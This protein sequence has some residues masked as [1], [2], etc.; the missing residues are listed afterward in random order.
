M[1][2]PRSQACRTAAFAWLRSVLSTGEEILSR[3]LLRAGFS[4]EGSNVH[5]VGPQGIF[6][7]A[8]ITYYPLSITTTTG[9]PYQDAFDPSGDFLLY[10]YRGTDP[11]FHENR[12]LR[13]AMRDR[14]PLIYFHSTVPG[15]YLAIFPV[16]IVGD[17]PASF[18][19][20]VAADDLMSISYERDDDEPKIRR[21]YLT[22]LV[23]HRIHQ[24][25]FRD[26]VLS[27]YRERCSICSLKHSSLL[28]AAHITPDSDE[29]GEPL[30]G[31]GLSLCKLHH[32]AFDRSMFG[33]K[34]TYEIEVRPDI[35]DE[36]DGPMLLHGL[37]AID[38]KRIL[39]PLRQRDR[40]DPERLEAR[41]ELFRSSV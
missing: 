5:L 22:R 28:D 10:R 24:Q 37:Q 14:I 27:A 7:P 38:K 16:L 25:T 1:E 41:Y 33:I 40:P 31:N 15:R 13:D 35:L 32:A 9:G 6:K 29:R 39:L 20:T 12:R 23:R 17:D 8:Q 21:G 30:V 19:F 34:P 18:T 4:F 26:R 2:D 11:N 36:T 3:E